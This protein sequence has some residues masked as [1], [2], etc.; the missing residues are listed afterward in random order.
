VHRFLI[1]VVACT[2]ASAA[3]FADEHATHLRGT[4]ALTTTSYCIQNSASIGFTPNFLPKGPVFPFSI[5]TE[6]VMVFHA[7]GT[8]TVN[9][10]SFVV[11]VGEGQT[12]ESSYQFTYTIDPDRTLSVKAVPG[13]QSS[14]V[15]TGPLAGLTQVAGVPDTSGSIGEGAR[16]ITLAQPTP[17]VQIVTRSTGAQFARICNG[18]TIAF[19]TSD[20]D[21]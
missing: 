12:S 11:D 2:T 8:G 15:L 10:R 19:R 7:D 3:A 17:S 14:T 6:G 1:L 13:T 9:Q 20:D 4:Y 21:R 5:T 18:S 16:A